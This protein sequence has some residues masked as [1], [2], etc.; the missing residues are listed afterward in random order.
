VT[1]FSSLG[2]HESL[3]STISDLGYETPT[4]VQEQAIPFVLQ[5]EDVLA[6]AQ[7]GTGKTAAFALP[8]ITRFLNGVDKR[9]I[10]VVSPTR[11]LAEQIGRVL[12]QLTKNTPQLKTAVI[13]GGS[14]YHH[15]MKALKS[16]PTFV[17][18]TPGRLIDQCRNRALRLDSFGTLVVD[19]ADRLLD[20]GF[21][22]QLRQVMSALPAERQTLMFSATL[23]REIENLANSFLKAP[24]RVSVGAITK[25][26]EKIVQTVVKTTNND[27]NETLMREI[28]KIAG[29]MIV[30]TKTKWR[31]D[32]V[33]KFL[34][35]IGHEVVRIHGDRSQG[36]RSAAINDFRRG[37]ARI[38]V[39]TDIASRGIDI[40]DIRYVVN[41]D[42]PASAEDYVHR[43]GRTGRAGTEG[44]AIAFVTP[45]EERLWVRI[46]HVLNG[47]GSSPRQGGRPQQGNKSFAQ[48]P[49]SRQDSRPQRSERRNDRS[50]GD[51]KQNFG[52]AGKHEGGKSSFKSRDNFR[53]QNRQTEFS[54]QRADRDIMEATRDLESKDRQIKRFKDKSKQEFGGFAG[55]RN[56]SKGDGFRRREDRDN[57]A[58]SRFE[59]SNGESSRFSR[60]G[61][62]EH[63][64][65]RG[66]GPKSGAPRFKRYGDQAE[67][68]HSARSSNGGG[69][70]SSLKSSD[71]PRFNGKNG[72]GRSFGKPSGGKNG[73]SGSWSSRLGNMFK[74][75]KSRSGSFAARSRDNY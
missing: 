13:I 45:E 70:D 44:C 16:N 42:L 8:V 41:Y 65:R 55:R 43:I 31:T 14:S 22:P 15:Q 57:G 38:L 35:S 59:N 12:G 4:P 74:G 33:A 47:K 66:Q 6:T 37:N 52:S 30:F 48:K 2:L 11:E 39:A 46:N 17:V 5:G 72:S 71:K 73:E 18:G 69:F 62:G 10:L 75:K 9:P 21:E 36:Q 34:T 49:S 1:Q 29:S 27:K 61:G 32:K 28:D 51:F 63:F 20:M 67:S 40:P 25:P 53:F 54:E 26:V 68:S 23:P 58:P 60:K 24:K 7:T 50:T 64:S 19:E 56:A 3:L